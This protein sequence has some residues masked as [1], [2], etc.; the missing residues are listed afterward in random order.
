[1]TILNDDF[2]VISKVEAS[3][4]DDARVI[5]YDLHMFMVQATGANPIVLDK[6]LP[7]N[8]KTKLTKLNTLPLF[9]IS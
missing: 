8:Y 2:R 4:T 3:L 9:V 1:M 5:I 6:C 7:C